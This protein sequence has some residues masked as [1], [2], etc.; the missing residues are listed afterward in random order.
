MLVADGGFPPLEFWRNEIAGLVSEKH[1][2]G[3][4]VEKQ[5]LGLM[6]KSAAPF[7]RG[8]PPAP[9]AAGHHSYHF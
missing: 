4:L 1:K 6:Q 7:G 2:I 8:L 3:L 9:R 5:R